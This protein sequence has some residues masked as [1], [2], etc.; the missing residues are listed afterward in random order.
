MLPSNQLFNIQREYQQLLGLIEESEGELTPEIDQALQ[1]TEQKMQEVGVNIGGVIKTLGYWADDITAEIERLESLLA[2][3]NKG[4]ELLKTRLSV[5]MHQFGIER[6]S[7]PTITISFRKSEAVEIEDEFDLP[8]EYFDQQ[9]PKV[10]KIRIREALK[11]GVY[12]PGAELVT[13]SNIQIK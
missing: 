11:A 1:F 9:A 2:K 7:S 12:V 4:R 5:A 10:S 6:I 3:A 8:V 13:R